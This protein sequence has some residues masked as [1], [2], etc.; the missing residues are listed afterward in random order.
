MERRSRDRER[1]KLLRIEIR[2][3]RHLF[4]DPIL[5]LGKHETRTMESPFPR[6]AIVRTHARTPLFYGMRFFDR[7]HVTTRSHT[8]RNPVGKQYTHAAATYLT[9]KPRVKFLR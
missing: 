2:S 3:I 7:S 6:F 1:T 4:R 8:Y 9:T 5:E